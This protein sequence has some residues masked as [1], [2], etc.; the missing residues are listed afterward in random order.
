MPSTYVSVDDIDAFLLDYTL[1]EKEKALVAMVTEVETRMKLLARN[2]RKRGLD[3][4]G[5][6]YIDRF[7]W[8]TDCSMSG[9]SAPVWEDRQSP[10]A[11]A[12]THT[13]LEDHLARVGMP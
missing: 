13:V 12:S 11:T 10:L 9:K 8:L 4:S 5:A 2:W 7:D 1:W 3:L 6:E